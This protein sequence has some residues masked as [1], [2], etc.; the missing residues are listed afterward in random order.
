MDHEEK[1]EQLQRDYD[2]FNDQ[3]EGLGGCIVGILLAVLVFGGL[4]F[5]IGFCV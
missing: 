2:E 3:D 1:F 5:L 4:G